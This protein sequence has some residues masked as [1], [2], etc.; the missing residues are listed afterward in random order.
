MPIGIYKGPGPKALASSSRRLEGDHL[1]P[2]SPFVGGA[3]RPPPWRRPAVVPH[4]WPCSCLPHSSLPSS[5]SF[6][7]FTPP[8]RRFPKHSSSRSNRQGLVLGLCGPD[9]VPRQPHSCSCGRLPMASLARR[10]WI[11]SGQIWCHPLRLLPAARSRRSPASCIARLGGAGPSVVGSPVLI[12]SGPDL[13]RSLHRRPRQARP[14]LGYGCLPI[15]V[16]CWLVLC[17]CGRSWPCLIEV[18][19]G[20]AGCGV[21]MVVWSA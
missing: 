5:L 18:L 16:P 19:L 4:N 9:P 17:R 1:L 14:P 13:E 3:R 8:L 10:C 12:P 6:P 15:V 11:R 21:V 2:L 7:D 20:S